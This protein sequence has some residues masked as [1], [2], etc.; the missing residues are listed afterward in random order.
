LIN[1]SQSGSSPAL[2]LRAV[3]GR[4]N[5]EVLAAGDDGT[6]LSVDTEER[7]VDAEETDAAASAMALGG[8][9]GSGRRSVGG[10]DRGALMEPRACALRHSSSSARPQH[11]T[12]DAMRICRRS[13]TEVCLSRDRTHGV[14]DN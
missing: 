14:T 3:G 7:H 1:I 9:D 6:R 4:S 11:N 12:L 8:V 13:E 2:K 10:T 5:D